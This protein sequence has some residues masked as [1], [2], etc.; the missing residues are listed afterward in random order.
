VTK[1]RLA[2]VLLPLACVAVGCASSGSSTQ[3]AVGPKLLHRI[4]S[5]VAGAWRYEASTRDAG[6]PPPLT[7]H[8]LRTAVSTVDPHYVSAVVQL[9]D[10][11]GRPHG[12]PVIAIFNSGRSWMVDGPAREFPSPCAAGRPAGVRSLICP[13]PWRVLGYPQ[14]R[15]EAQTSLTQQIP[16][17]DLR[18]LDWSKVQL[19]GAACGSSRPIRI[20]KSG[21]G[22]GTTIHPDVD[23]LWWNPVVVSE[24]TPVLGGHNE[25]ALTVVCSNDGGTADGQLA[26]SVVV[27]QAQGHVLRVLGILRPHAA[28]NPYLG[29]VPLVGFPKFHGNAISVA[30]TWYGSSD[31]TCCGS[32]RAS[33]LW[34]YREGRF[35][36]RTTI[37]Q[38]P[39]ASPI[40]IDDFVVS[41][42]CGDTCRRVPLTPRLHFTVWLGA[43]GRVAKRV[44]VTLTVRQG[45]RTIRE[46][47]SVPRLKS[48][49]LGA[50]LVFGSFHGLKPGAVRVTVDLHRAGAFPFTYRYV[51]IR[52]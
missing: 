14:P 4:S 16:T 22:L 10:K 50:K 31:G 40:T 13:N 35:H 34:T 7:A 46:T 47:K 23:L 32:G 9:R 30:E 11:S 42:R 2:V 49:E 18:Q 39:W 8:V 48:E 17:S 12:L 27:F 37:I 26:F 29:H 41:A 38:R 20:D 51:L 19:P 28:L 15:L 3:P 5:S 44:A 24:E 52:S 21:Y 33:T 45:T 43:Y 6:A 1:R 25:A 36:P